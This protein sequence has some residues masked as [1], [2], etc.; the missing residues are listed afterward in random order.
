MPQKALGV[1]TESMLYTMMALQAGPRCGSEIAVWVEQLTGG[2]VLLGPGTLYT[3]LS[4]FLEEGYLCETAT[5]GRK[6]TYALTAAGRQAYTNEL[7]RLQ[8]CI[9]DARAALCRAALEGD[10]RLEKQDP[11]RALAPLPAL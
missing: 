11:H 8:R 9:D 10:D 1:M 4:K 2:R 7:D 5:D 3:I 6:R